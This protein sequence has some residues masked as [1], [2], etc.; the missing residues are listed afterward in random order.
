MEDYFGYDVHLVMNIT[1]ID[2]KVGSRALTLTFYSSPLSQI[3]LRA[4]QEHLIAELSKQYST[5]NQDLVD[6]AQTS[7]EKYLNSKVLKSIPSSELE[8]QSSH[9]QAQWNY[10]QARI[11]DPS[12]LEAA[13]QRDEKFSMHVTNLVRVS[14]HL[15]K[16]DHNQSTNRKTRL[17]PSNLQEPG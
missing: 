14:A 9:L 11:L 7:W 13:L 16:A 3:I 6:L 1:D 8:A 17:A 10:V 15:I 5:L 12:W 4:R 2:D